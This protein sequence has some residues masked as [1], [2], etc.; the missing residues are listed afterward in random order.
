MRRALATLLLASALCLPAGGAELRLAVAGPAETVFDWATQRCEA[1]DVPDAPAR[2][3]RLADG[4][5]RLIAAHHKN[6]VMAGPELGEVRPDC[7]VTYQAGNNPDPAAHDGHGWIAAPWTPDGRTVHAL[8]HMEYHGNRHKQFCPS[9][10]YMACWGNAIT[11]VTSTDG[12]ATFTRPAGDAVVAAGSQPY[13]G[14][15]GRRQGIFQPSNVVTVGACRVVAVWAEALGAQRRGQCLVR[16]CDSGA[17]GQWLAWDGADFTTD[18]GGPVGG[19]PGPTC[20][21]VSPEV[22]T[23]SLASITRHQ[24]TGL[25]VGL[26]AARRAPQPGAAA[27]VGIWSTISADLVT[28]TWPVLVQAMPVMTAFGCTDGE[29]FAY[30]SLIDPKSSSLNFE[31]MAD[32]AFLYLT[33]IKTNGCKL[34]QDRDLVR[35]PV[36]VSGIETPQPEKNP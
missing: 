9:G 26:M 19:Q 23:N 28:W 6:R 25:Y 5:V 20:A 27:E 16:N 32:T 13:D 11:L 31:D 22:L 33:R 30:P 3:W 12:G 4:S 21:P 2:A 18:L 10:R 1:W 36:T 17:P 7:R 24:A 35:V 15:A 14:E 8:V 29:A 34:T